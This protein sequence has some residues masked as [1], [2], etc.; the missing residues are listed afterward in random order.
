LEPTF[1]ISTFLSQQ[2]PVVVVMGLVIYWLQKR[3]DK[4]EDVIKLKDEQLLDLSKDVIKV[5][6]L[7]EENKKDPS[8]KEFQDKVLD[9]LTEV[10]DIVH[11]C[12]A[13]K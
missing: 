5:A 11:E 3:L 1:D 13:K 7:W 6:T 4:K 9:L 2:I 8:N 10:K 12:N